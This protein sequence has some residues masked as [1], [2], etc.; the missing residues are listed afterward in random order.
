MSENNKKVK[1]FFLMALQN[2]KANNFKVAENLYNNFLKERPDHF[3]A[4]F[5]LG[6]LYAQNAKLQL[7]KKF[8]SKAV[9]IKPDSIDANVNLGAVL[10]ELGDYQEAITFSE[11][12]IK[13]NP[14]HSV[15]YNNLG[16]SLKDTG[17]YQKALSFFKKAIQINPNFINAHTNIALV[18]KELRKIDDEMHCYE[19]LNKMKPNSAYVQQNLGRL[20]LERG[21]IK[22]SINSFK[23]A[24]K[25]DSNNFLYYY[26]LSD[27]E[28][29][30]LNSKLKEKISESIK[31]K[32]LT[33]KN[34]SYANFLLSKYELKEKNYKR[35][36][37]YLLEGHANYFE[38]RS[39][40]FK[41]DIKYWLSVLPKKIKLINF[42]DLKKNTD[43]SN[44]SIKPIFIIGVPRSGSTLIEKLITS[45]DQMIISGEEANILSM[46]V[47]DKINKNEPIDADINNFKE[48][49]IKRYKSKE[50]IQE[51]DHLCFTDK[52]LDN[53]FY[54]GLIKFIFPNAKIINCKRNAISS[55]MS[56]LKNNLPGIPWAHD[57]NNIFKY[58]DIYY[59]VI[60][61]Y[62]KKIPNFIYDIE[63]EKLIAKP[64]EEAK[65]LLEFCNIPWNKKCLDFYKRK[66]LVSRTT[67]NYQI[68]KAIN[69]D[70]SKI[71]LPYKKFLKN[72]SKK[73]SWF[74]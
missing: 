36:F 42:D 62:K 21:H 60:K 49:I 13:I 44:F 59:N 2:H 72:Y 71:Y 34:L 1:E 70:S 40:K 37:N 10:A 11:N 66:D 51:K 30:I 9:Q 3:Q 73:Y 57:L 50:L 24:I 29:G 45:S 54:I 63:L 4:I 61:F 64:E 7:A 16:A 43:D 6:A 17:D 65:K 41:N 8:F 53:F 5:N 27:L 52:S 25:Y 55:I 23:S 46:T 47:R 69:N 20:Y 35:E 31:N 26:L 33:K 32:K 15:A 14:N 12:A 39:D 56:I 38:S 58:F 67:S 22:E 18:F 48:D 28:K 74:N 68:R 19:K